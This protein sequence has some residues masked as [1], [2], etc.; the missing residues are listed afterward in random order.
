MGIAEVNPFEISGILGEI[1]IKKFRD[2]ARISFANDKQ[3]LN[4]TDSLKPLAGTTFAVTGETHEHS[5]AVDLPI[6]LGCTKIPIQCV[7]QLSYVIRRPGETASDIKV[8]RNNR[9]T[10][11]SLQDFASLIQKS[12][13]R[14]SENKTKLGKWMVGEIGGSGCLHGFNFAL[15]GNHSHQN[16]KDIE[17]MLNYHGGNI[18]AIS[19]SAKIH[20]VISS[21]EGVNITPEH[22]QIINILQPKILDRNSLHQLVQFLSPYH[23]A[24]EVLKHVL[25][26]SEIQGEATKED[27]LPRYS[28]RLRGL[29]FGIIGQ[30]KVAEIALLMDLLQR[31]GGQWHPMQLDP[32]KVDYVLMG[33]DVSNAEVDF[34]AKSAPKALIIDRK[35]LVRL[36]LFPKSGVGEISKHGIEDDTEDLVSEKQQKVCRV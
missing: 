17:H 30:R 34:K 35:D 29:N 5:W 28:K 26:R 21:N 6:K 13:A 16:G 8:L 22:R 15:T 3:P 10:V 1:G 19:S 18:T 32:R 9:P 20:Y 7:N 27:L 25:G 36:I 14:G 31:H 12:C 2:A 33:N 4:I 24:N 23:R 11:I